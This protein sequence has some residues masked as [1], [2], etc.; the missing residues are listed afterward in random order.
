MKRTLTI[1]FLLCFLGGIASAQV[2][3]FAVAEIT[4]DASAF[5]TITTDL[6]I[7]M[8]VITAASGA[9]ASVKVYDATDSTGASATTPFCNI[10]CATGET[11]IWGLN[12]YN[13]FR[14]STGVYADITGS[15]AKA[16]I[17]R[18]KW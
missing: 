6:S 13:Y 1:L 11:Q 9:A 4:A 18:R 5:A 16:Y 12:D 2:N 8:V 15:G 17:Y 7:S 14:C 3:E 10:A